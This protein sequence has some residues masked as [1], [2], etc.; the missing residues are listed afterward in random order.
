VAVGLCTALGELIDPFLPISNLGMLYLL[1]VV[2]VAV[3]AGRG[4]AVATALLSVAAFN[5]FF[6][7]PAI[8]SMLVMQST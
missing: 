1:A 6:V 8:P 3:F 5:F 4:P 7:P 2:A